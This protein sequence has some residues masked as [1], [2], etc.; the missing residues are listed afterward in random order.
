MGTN[1]F[2][3]TPLQLQ[4][5]GNIKWVTLSVLQ[6]SCNMYVYYFPFDIQRC[7]IQVG[8]WTQVKIAVQTQLIKALV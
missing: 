4:N 6:V 3:D 1:V 5:N 8:S 7:N 2:A